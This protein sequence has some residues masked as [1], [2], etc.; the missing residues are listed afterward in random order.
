MTKLLAF[1][2]PILPGKT[3]QWKKFANDLTTR[4]RNEFIESRKNLG[5]YERAFYQT[6]PNGDIV[7]ITLEGQNPEA[8]LAKFGHGTDEFSKWFTAQVKEIHGMDLTQK[9]AHLPELMI[10]SEPIRA[11]ATASI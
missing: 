6:T 10:A 7:I 3:E 8:A 9:P 5:I 2:A 4:Y 11:T 1:A